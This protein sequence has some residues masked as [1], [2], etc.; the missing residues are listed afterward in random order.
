MTSHQQH[1]R[2]RVKNIETGFDIS[3]QGKSNY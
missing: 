1:S 2:I 3:V